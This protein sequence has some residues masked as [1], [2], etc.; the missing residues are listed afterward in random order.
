METSGLWG[1]VN[2]SMR[3][4][5]LR[6]VPGPILQKCRPCEGYLR[7]WACLVSF[8]PRGW[9]TCGAFTCPVEEFGRSH[10]HSHG[11]LD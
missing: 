5:G 7:A 2:G 11:L 1:D 8:G 3:S 10:S 9:D 6:K 4:A